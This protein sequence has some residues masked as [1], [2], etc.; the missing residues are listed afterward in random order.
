MSDSD[1][2][3]ADLPTF[4]AEHGFGVDVRR[5]ERLLA[6]VLEAVAREGKSGSLTIKIKVAPDVDGQT[7]VTT[8]DSSAVV[9]QP[10]PAS[11]T[12]YVAGRGLRA[13]D[14]AQPPLP[15]DEA[16]AGAMAVSSSSDDDQADRRL[17]AVR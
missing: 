11:Q 9:P 6:D 14:P 8:I 1:T 5:A 7:V 12:S 10:S 2:P 15:L 3:Q 4:L 17:A 13:Q 16:T